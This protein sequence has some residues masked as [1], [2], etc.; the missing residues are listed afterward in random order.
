[1]K[2]Q[3]L[4]VLY[5]VNLTVFCSQNLVA[6]NWDDLRSH[7]KEENYSITYADTKM[8]SF[9]QNGNLDDLKYE[10][11]RQK[12]QCCEAFDMS[13]EYVAHATFG[14]KDQLI[15]GTLLHFAVMF[16]QI[17]IAKWLLDNGVKIDVTGSSFKNTALHLACKYKH[18][19][20]A[21]LLLKFGAQVDILNY[22]GKTALF[23]ACD[24]GQYKL[25]SL[26]VNHS[27][28]IHQKNHIGK[29]PVDY[30]DS[31]CKSCRKI[32]S[33]LVSLGAQPKQA[34]DNRNQEERDDSVQEHADDSDDDED[35]DDD[36]TDE[37]SAD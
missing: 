23:Y 26:L 17:E 18:F 32:K 35:E 19:A 20:M 11:E 14:R 16:N 36:S 21:Q 37:E 2:N 5:A 8:I 13:K 34:E 27:A 31:E 9:I 25:V 22:V 15:F 24:S 29:T 12:Q 7:L 28:N 3:F 1:M 6:M 10:I 33:L 4:F 30:V